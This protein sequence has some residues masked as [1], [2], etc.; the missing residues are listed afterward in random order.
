MIPLVGLLKNNNIRCIMFSMINLT[1]KISILLIVLVATGLK[2]EEGLKDKHKNREYF[3]VFAHV[4]SIQKMEN[5]AGLA[6]MEISHVYKGPENLKNKTFSLVVTEG[7]RFSVP[8]LNVGE[9]GVWCVTIIKENLQP[10]LGEHFGLWSPTRKKFDKVYYEHILRLADYIEGYEKTVAPENKVAYLKKGAFNEVGE[11]S[12]WAI[13]ELSYL[14][15]E[16]TNEYLYGLTDASDLSVLGKLKLDE[17]LS[18]VKSKE[19][20]YAKER[21]EYLYSVFS[22]KE[23]SKYE[24][25][26][27]CRYL[28]LLLQTRDEKLF[29]EV[30]LIAKKV[31]NNQDLD[32][33]FRGSLLRYFRLIL[34]KD[35]YNDQIF[36]VF[37]TEIRNDSDGAE[38]ALYSIKNDFIMDENKKEILIGLKKQIQNKDRVKIITEILEKQN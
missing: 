28:G 16:I 5:E 37:V 31:L 29:D 1:K 6:I 8:D 9:E 14:N 4:V 36:D 32:P 35:K 24:S 20:S 2:S 12:A 11:I 34:S 21:F 19:W 30:L 25:D 7:G 13:N 15:D 3:L 38:L 18:R 23:I 10:Q 26:K 22:M 17:V 33:E 27:L